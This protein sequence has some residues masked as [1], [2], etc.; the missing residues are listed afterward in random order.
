MP[1]TYKFE[2]VEAKVD[3]VNQKRIEVTEPITKKEYITLG[4]LKAQL[5]NLKAQKDS[6]VEVIEAKEAEIVEIK[7]ALNITEED[8]GG[9]DVPIEEL[10]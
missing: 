6:I 10:I 5:S 1:K 3:D 2:E 7:S 8:L 4:D 9:K